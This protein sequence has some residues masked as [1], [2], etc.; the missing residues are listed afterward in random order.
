MSQSRLK[1]WMVKVIENHRSWEVLAEE[2]RGDEA[3][4]YSFGLPPLSKRTNFIYRPARLAACAFRGYTACPPTCG[5]RTKFS[6]WWIDATDL[7][8]LQRFR[9]SALWLDTSRFERRHLRRNLTR[10]KCRWLLSFRST[11]HHSKN[12]DLSRS[13][14]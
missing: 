2:K 11:I 5:Q 1:F 8:R 3:A 6:E 13:R 4:D 10:Q 9:T 12:K 7:H 14:T